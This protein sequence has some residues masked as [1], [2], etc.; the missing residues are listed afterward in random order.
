MVHLLIKMCIKAIPGLSWM[1]RGIELR[2]VSWIPTKP[3]N[4]SIL[5]SMT[6]SA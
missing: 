3:E 6:T 2:H 5:M 4:L 1:R